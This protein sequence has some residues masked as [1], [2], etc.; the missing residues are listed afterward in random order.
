M[1]LPVF[2]IFKC[3]GQRL[4]FTV[5]P[6]GQNFGRKAQKGPKKKLDGLGKSGAELFCQRPNFLADLGENS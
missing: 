1:P 4:A 2:G 6:R 5:L 3:D